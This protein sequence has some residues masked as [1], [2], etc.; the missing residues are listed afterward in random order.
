[1]K[2]I[3]VCFSPAVFDCYRNPEAV[4]VVVDVLRATSAICTAFMNGVYTII[5]V[6]HVEEARKY[7]QKGFLVAAERDGLV[8]DFADFGN[9]P[10]NFTRERVEGREIVYST[11]N[12]TKAI[13]FANSCNKVAV[14]SFLNITALCNWIVRSNRDVIILCAGWK[15]KFCI[16]DNLL[17]GAIAEK[18]IEKG[19]Y[20]TSCDSTMAALD[21]WS[22]AKNNVMEYVEKTAQRNRLKKNGLDDVI[23]FCFTMDQTAIVPE[24]Q[25]GIILGNVENM[26]LC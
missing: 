11:T 21:L 10:Y 9:S 15:N 7:K 4:A 20:V 26:I 24:Y 22:M 18:L 25:K 12:G 5:P 13:Q 3:E 19:K 17:A 14:G 6:E 1:M 8:L 23:E 2:N 16:E